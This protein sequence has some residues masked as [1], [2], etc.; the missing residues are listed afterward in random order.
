MSNISNPIKHLLRALA[1]RNRG[2]KVEAKASIQNHQS[3]PRESATKHSE[4][5]VYALYTPVITQNTVEMVEEYASIREISSKAQLT[6]DYEISAYSP[7]G[8][9][10]MQE[11]LRKSLKERIEEGSLRIDTLPSW[12]KTV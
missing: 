8:V 3:T 7:D 12:W 10:M 9:R 4:I 2:E 1:P 6:K 5:L 11:F